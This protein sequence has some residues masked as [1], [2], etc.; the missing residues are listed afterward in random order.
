M[1]IIFAGGRDFRDIEIANTIL[2]DAY[3]NNFVTDECIGISGTAKGADSIFA[4]LI[5]NYGGE[6]IPYP[7]KWDDLIET[8]SNPVNIKINKFEKEYNSLAGFNRNK[9]MAV[10]SDKLVA[11]YK[12]SGGTKDMINLMIKL[13]KPVR[14]YNYCGDF[15]GKNLKDLKL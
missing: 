3:E 14:I 2:M 8:E 13:N 5:N 15:I 1:K 10:N 9:L 4:Y 12:G 6:V 11:V 7:A